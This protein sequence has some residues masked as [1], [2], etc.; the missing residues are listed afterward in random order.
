MVGTDEHTEKSGVVGPVDADG[1]KAEN[2]GAVLGPEMAEGVAQGL[3]SGEHRDTDL[4][5]QQRDGD[6]EDAIAEGFEALGAFVVLVLGA[7][8]S[9]GGPLWPCYNSRPRVTPM[10]R[11]DRATRPFAPQDTPTSGSGRAGKSAFPRRKSGY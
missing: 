6:G 10:C 8:E 3:L 7:T 9:H 1:D 5:N 2:V 11:R 4:D